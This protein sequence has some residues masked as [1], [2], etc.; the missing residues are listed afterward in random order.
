MRPVEGEA[1]VWA[2]DRCGHAVHDISEGTRN[3]A[4]ALIA[5]A[6]ARGDRRICVR[7][8]T[9]DRG[10]I[11]Y[12]NPPLA[13]MLLVRA[14]RLA[15]A[16]ALPLALA[17]CDPPAN[18][19]QSPV[20][21]PTSASAA[22]AP[23]ALVSVSPL[24]VESGSASETAACDTLVPAADSNAKPARKTDTGAKK[25][26]RPRLAGVIRLHDD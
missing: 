11:R 16:A 2:C 20:T 12:A 8:E 3:E 26:R 21:P 24:P 9:D 14:R 7:Y 5:T 4:R 6:R 19:E 17:A 25:R 18:R 23:A 13:P 22:P 1:R 15:T 10:Q